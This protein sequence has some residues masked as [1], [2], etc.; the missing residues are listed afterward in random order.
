MLK[1]GKI[2]QVHIVSFA[3][4]WHLPEVEGSTIAFSPEISRISTSVTLRNAWAVQEGISKQ[5]SGLGPLN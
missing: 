3:V 1:P 4:A 2:I 5:V